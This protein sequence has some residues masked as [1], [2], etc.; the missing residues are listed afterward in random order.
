MYV[1]LSIFLCL[2]H[3]VTGVCVSPLLGVTVGH[4]GLPMYLPLSGFAFAKR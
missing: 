3:G 2:H 4:E 1:Y